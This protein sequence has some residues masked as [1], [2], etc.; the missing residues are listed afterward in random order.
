M[1]MTSGIRRIWL[2]LAAGALVTGG[3][4]A[5]RRRAIRKA[6]GSDPFQDWATRFWLSH[7]ALRRN[8][9]RFVQIVER[10]EPVD[11]AAFGEYVGLY[12]KFLI[13]HHESEDQVVFPTLRRHGRLRTTDAAHLDGWSVEHRQVN[14]LAE[15]LVQAGA[16]VRSRGRSALPEVGRASRE[17]GLLLR[18]H[19]TAEEELISPSHLEEMVPARAIAEIE[20]ASRQLFGRVREIPLF[21]AHSLNEDEQ[22]QVFGATPWIFRKVIFPLMDRRAGFLRFSPFV[23]SP[24]LSRLGV[25][26]P[27]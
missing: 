15:A 12:G 11:P 2:P 24:S 19:L 22:R 20:R 25:L 10:D 5:A 26:A 14:A 6:L 27:R 18:P 21:F 1:K 9:D 13:V 23:V 4:I 7:E 8:L 17:L 16:Q 3:V